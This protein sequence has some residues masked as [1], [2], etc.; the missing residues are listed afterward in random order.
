MRRVIVAAIAAAIVNLARAGAL[1]SARWSI[2]HTS[3][4]REASSRR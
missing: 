3:G 2:E 1:E 4:P